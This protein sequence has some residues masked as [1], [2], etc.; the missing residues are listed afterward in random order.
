MNF[1]F[2]VLNLAADTHGLTQTLFF[3]TADSANYM[4]RLFLLDSYSKA[5]KNSKYFS[6]LIPI[7]RMLFL[8]TNVGTSLYFGITT[9]RI[10]PGKW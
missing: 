4:G 5:T 10:A 6:L 9:G 7:I 2:L 1:E 8:I 3:L